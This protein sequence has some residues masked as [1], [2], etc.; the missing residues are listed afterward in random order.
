M[1]LTTE[2]ITEPYD[3]SKDDYCFVIRTFQDCGGFCGDRFLNAQEKVITGSFTHRRAE[4]WGHP[5]MGPR[6]RAPALGGDMTCTVSLAADPF[7]F[8]RGSH[9]GSVQIWTI[10]E[11]PTSHSQLSLYHVQKPLSR[12]LS[13]F[14][15]RFCENPLTDT[16]PCSC[17]SETRPIARDSYSV[18]RA[19]EHPRG[20]PPFEGLILNGV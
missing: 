8:A 3:R 13:I 11:I 4:S 14:L 9:G 18:T 20:E 2:L 10:P 16:Y 12:A 6:I 5:Y 15:F 1:L 17:K 7:M 19:V